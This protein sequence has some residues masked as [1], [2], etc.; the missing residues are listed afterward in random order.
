MVSS[1]NLQVGR[2]MMRAGLSDLL[3]IG[4]GQLQFSRG[5]KGKPLLVSDKSS[6]AARVGFNISHQVSGIGSMLMHGVFIRLVT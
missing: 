5:E 4:S 6:S 2:L 1:C 3:K